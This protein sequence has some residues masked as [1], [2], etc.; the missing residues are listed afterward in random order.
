MRMPRGRGLEQ[1]LMCQCCEIESRGE[2]GYLLIREEKRLRKIL[3]PTAK[4]EIYTEDKAKVS[5]I[6]FDR[7]KQDNITIAQAK[8][9]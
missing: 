9:T 5:G 6:Q 3:G 8:L 4:N 1:E 7:L 2:E